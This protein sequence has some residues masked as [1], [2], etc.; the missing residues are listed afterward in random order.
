MIITNSSAIKVG[1]NA[2]TLI[3]KGSNKVYE[4]TDSA[5]WN[6]IGIYSNDVTINKINGTLVN[7]EVTA[8]VSTLVKDVSNVQSFVLSAPN[9]SAVNNL[10]FTF[11]EELVI[12]N[13]TNYRVHKDV[14]FV[15]TIGTSSSGNDEYR[16][17]E[18]SSDGGSS[19]GFW[20]MITVE[21]TSSGGVGT[22][23]TLTIVSDQP[24]VNNPSEIDFSTASNAVWSGA[25]IGSIVTAD[26]KMV[27]RLRIPST[28]SQDDDNDDLP[29]VGIKDSAFLN[30]NKLT[31]VIIPS[32]VTSIGNSAFQNCSGVRTVNCMA[33]SAPTI[34][35]N[36]FNGIE[37][38]EIH[39]PASASASYGSTYGGLTVVADQIPFKI[40]G[41][42]TS[43]VQV[44]VNGIMEKFVGVSLSDD[45]DF[46]AHSESFTDT[47]PVR[48]RFDCV[49]GGSQP[50]V[51]DGDSCV[52]VGG[53]TDFSAFDGLNDGNINVTWDGTS[54]EV[55]IDLDVDLS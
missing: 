33:T 29:V 41:D 27:G 52:I 5:E 44:T 48:I 4:K 2:A 50:A 26:L 43:A 15:K 28:L 8:G 47:N 46:V 31:S 40:K 6:S 20:M 18:K 25:S 37:A 51:F 34:G 7:H 54:S 21:E 14:Y 53:T 30:Q 23:S 19:Q 24:S 3:F 16:Y 17:F 32:S 13:S 11:T 42:F 12:G 55:T 38:T 35:T 49:R 1:S 9:Y 45:G 10:T 36:A 39:V 22:L